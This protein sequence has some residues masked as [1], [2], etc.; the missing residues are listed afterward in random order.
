MA[1]ITKSILGTFS[2]NIFVYILG[3]AISIFVTNYLGPEGKGVYAIFTTNSEL[4][5]LFVCFSVPNALTYF[6]ANK[7]FSSYDIGNMVVVTTLF[8]TIIL[9]VFVFSNIADGFLLPEVVN[10]IEFKL[11][12]SGFVLLSLS[13][14]FLT[15][16]LQG[17]KDFKT[18]NFVNLMVSIFTVGVFAYFFF[19]HKQ[20]DFIVSVKIAIWINLSLVLASILF[21]YRK[22][23]KKIKFSIKGALP[24]FFKNLKT[25]AAYVFFYH[26]TTLANFLIY[27]MSYWI[28]IEYA[29]EYEVGIFALAFNLAFMTRLLSQA[30][31]AVTFPYFTQ[32][33]LEK[34]LKKS[35]LISRVLFF[36][37]LVVNLTLFLFAGQIIPALYGDQFI[38][39]LPYLRILL[40]GIFFYIQASVFSTF[41]LSRGI[42]KIQ[43]YFAA[44][45]LVVSIVLHYF[46]TIKVDVSYASLVLSIVFVFLFVLYA[47]VMMTKYKVK[48]KEF[49]FLNKSDLHHFIKLVK[50]RSNK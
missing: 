9:S 16:Y 23:R 45:G 33:S 18:I 19:F 31:A 22:A 37:T 44:A 43:F 17:A 7:K 14:T 24:L 48:I 30:I 50:G 41:L 10:N 2:T 1:N 38:A 20:S 28:I 12:F 6:V 35:L 29:G 39:S 40:P 8:S 25:S 47:W 15:A 13:K 26:L 34:A 46:L 11:L 27:R 36:L 4:F 21:F 3:F 5:V 42:T 32:E 49:V